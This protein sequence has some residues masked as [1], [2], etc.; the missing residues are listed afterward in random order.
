M[1]TP[2]CYHQANR[3]PLP[4]VIA[5]THADGTVDLQVND[6]V[7]VTACQLGR[8]AAPGTCTLTNDAPPSPAP[9]R[10]TRSKA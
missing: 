1:P 9:A 7:I 3:P 6:Q 8:T 5:E 2:A 4:C 10:R